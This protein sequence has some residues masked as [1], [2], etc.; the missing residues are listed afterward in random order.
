MVLPA[1]ALRQQDESGNAEFGHVGFVLSIHWHFAREGA[2]RR[3]TTLFD[4]GYH[5]RLRAD[6]FE[7]A[8]SGDGN[9]REP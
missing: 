7:K 2:G 6:H 8:T 3:K 5:L 9:V 4:Q 1:R